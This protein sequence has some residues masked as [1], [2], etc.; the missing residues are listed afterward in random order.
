MKNVTLSL[1]EEVAKWAK[2]WAAEH[3]TSVSKMLSDLLKERMESAK[4][5]QNAMTSFLAREPVELKKG[6]GYPSRDS[7]YE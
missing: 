2:V 4:N 7:I 6:K 5:Y 1:P 3:D